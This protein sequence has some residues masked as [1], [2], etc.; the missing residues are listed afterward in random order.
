MDP[1]LLSMIEAG[2]IIPSAEE[3][4]EITQMSSESRPEVSHVAFVQPDE[5]C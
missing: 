2:L 3:L 5:V 1:L 4:E